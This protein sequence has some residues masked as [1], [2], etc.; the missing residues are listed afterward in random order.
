MNTFGQTNLVP[1]NFVLT[2]FFLT[3]YVLTKYVLTNY[4][5]TN[6]ILINCVLTNFVRTKYVR[7]NFILS[8]C[9]LTNYAR[10]KY[11]RTNMPTILSKKI[12]FLKFLITL[13]LKAKAAKIWRI[14]ISKINGATTFRITA[15]SRTTLRMT[16]NFDKQQNVTQQYDTGYTNFNIFG[17]IAFCHQCY[18]PIIR[19]IADLTGLSLNRTCRPNVS[20]QNGIRPKDG[21]QHLWT[22][23]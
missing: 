15:L 10:T 3:N 14:L 17:N 21:E 23:L 4:V 8:N 5:L 12:F 9:V 20:R 18:S 16:L 22:V 13:T 19:L 1:A 11:V 6:F 2:N 7:T